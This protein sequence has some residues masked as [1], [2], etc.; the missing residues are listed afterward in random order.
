[1]ST[2]VFCRSP[3]AKRFRCV[4]KK[5]TDLVKYAMN[6]IPYGDRDRMV[7]AIMGTIGQ[8]G[9]VSVDVDIV[10]AAAWPAGRWEIVYGCL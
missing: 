1:V 3:I 4:Y 9:L 5:R 10:P 6:D 7:D 2:L 8:R